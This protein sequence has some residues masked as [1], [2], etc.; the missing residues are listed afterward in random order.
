MCRTK[1]DAKR[2][3]IAVKQWL[4][5]RLHLDISEEK[6]KIT[7]L[8]NEYSEFLGIKIK[9]RIKNNKRIV[10][11]Y[12]CDK[13]KEKT[14]RDLKEQVRRIKKSPTTKNIQRWNAMILGK[15]NYYNVATLVTYDFAEIGYSLLK[16]LHNRLRFISSNNG[17]KSETYMKYYGDYNSRTYYIRNIALFPIAGIKTKPPMNFS[18][19]I[20]DY[21]VGGRAKIHTNLFTIDIEI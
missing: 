19:D 17:R 12:M 6:S 20:C 21:T 13:A 3:F 15:H 14:K 7:C 16:T 9:T 8:N 5:E 10:T 11:S 2:I 18:Q 4:K 1:R